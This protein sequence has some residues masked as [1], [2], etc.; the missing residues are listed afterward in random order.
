MPRLLLLLL[1]AAT[2][3]AQPEKEEYVSMPDFIGKRV[4]DRIV[5][6]SRELS[7]CIIDSTARRCILQGSGR[8]AVSGAAVVPMPPSG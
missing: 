5:F 7:E 1:A 3:G 8:G 2:A 6:N 4:P